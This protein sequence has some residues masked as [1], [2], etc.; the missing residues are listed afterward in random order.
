MANLQP[1]T[2]ILIVSN[3]AP[4]TGFVEKAL[5][6]L[7]YTDVKHLSNGLE[8]IDLLIEQRFGLVVCDLN[9]RLISGW[10]FV[11]ELKTSDKVPNVPIV[12]VGSGDAPAPEDELNHYGVLKFLKVPFKDSE[13][14]FL[15][16]STTQLFKTSGT[17]ENKYTKAK[18][19][20]IKQ[21]SDAAID[22]YSELRHLTEN[23]TRSSIGLAQAHLQK[24]D[25][26]AATQVLA[27]SKG[28]EQDNPTSLILIAKMHYQRERKE[29]ARNSVDKILSLMPDAAFYY[30][31]CARLM[32]EHDDFEACEKVCEKALAKSFQLP[33][34]HSCIARCK[35]TS[36]RFDESLKIV[37]EAISKFGA[38]NEL[39]NI[40]GVCLK[41]LGNFAAAILCYEEALRLS[42]M[43]EKV[44]FNLAICESAMHHVDVATRHLEMCLK[45]APDFTRA[46]EK[47][48]EIKK[49]K[50]QKEAS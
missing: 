5:S 11:K 50:A 42:P 34:F 22:R 2:K 18:D 1:A 43:D 23:S 9:V 6:R 48:D 16:S 33:E 29:E 10:L 31:R 12:L 46:R 36:G 17:R 49:V 39:L 13:F 26:E 37:N 35:Y 38:S 32:L 19:A 14:D 24:D 21:E 7:N 27:N 8:A 45:I 44:Y 28:N 3:D 47:L 25:V 30:S 41:K 20:L 40:K 15:I 4:S